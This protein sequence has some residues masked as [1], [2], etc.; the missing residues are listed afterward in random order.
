MMAGRSGKYTR[1]SA[2]AKINLTLD[3]LGKREDG[4]HDLC[5]VMQSVALADT[6]EFLFHPQ[7]ELRLVSNHSFLPTGEKNLAHLAAR[8]F[9]ARL[10]RP[11]PGLELSLEKRIPVCAGLGGGSSDAAAVLRAL[12]RMEGEPFSP[13]EL[14]KLGEEVGSDVP[15]CVLGGTA[16][17]QGRGEILTPL[18]KLPW[19]WVVLCKPPF[20][21]STP[22]LF[23]R[24]DK[25]SLRCHPDTQGMMDYLEAGDL[26][27]VARRM[28]NVLEDALLPRQREAVEQIKSTLVAHGALGAAMSGSGPTVFG[29]FNDKTLAQGAYEALYKDFPETFF[30]HTV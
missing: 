5:M 26:G 3:V 25:V 21:V 6:L 28:Y 11:A 15:Y 13:S 9:Y 12:N 10:N 14:A 20:P 22:E 19:C 2:Y 8:R 18:S 17:A 16:L 24:L 23:T 30:T 4:Y 7:G 1:E 27:Q 29:I